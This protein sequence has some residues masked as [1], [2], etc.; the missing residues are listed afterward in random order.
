[1]EKRRHVWKREKKRGVFSN[2]KGFTMLEMLIA[3]T[4]FTTCAFSVPLLYDSA[5][6]IIKDS[7]AE[8]MMEWELFIIQLRND[9]QSSQNWQLSGPQIQYSAAGPNDSVVSISRYN[10]KIRRQINGKGHEV[11]LQDVKSASFSMEGG[12][13]YLSVTFSNGK[14]EIASIYSFHNQAP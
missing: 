11:M 6:R 1:M 12:N 9:M 10:D 7:K 13:V 3:L 8:K 14:Q 2:N 5:S 4:V